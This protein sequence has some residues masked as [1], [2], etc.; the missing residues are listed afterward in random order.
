[1]G[2]LQSVPRAECA[3]IASPYHQP[4]VISRAVVVG[5]EEVG[6]KEALEVGKV[7]QSLTAV[8]ENEVRGGRDGGIRRTAERERGQGRT[9]DGSVRWTGEGGMAPPR[10]QWGGC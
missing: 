8:E 6:L 5:V 10:H 1:M 3:W 4:T 9:G 7:L 2:I